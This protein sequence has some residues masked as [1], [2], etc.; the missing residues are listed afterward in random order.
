VKA[1]GTIAGT[2]R[3][4][5]SAV[6]SALL[7]VVLAGCGGGHDAAEKQ[8]EALR[9]ELVKVRTEAAILG[10]RLDALERS[11]EKVRSA[12]AAEEAPTTGADLAAAAEAD[13]PSLEVVRLAPEPQRGR[14]RG[15]ESGRERELES[16]RDATAAPLPTARL[17]EVVTTLDG[18]VDDEDEPRPVLR[19]TKGGG[20]IEAKPLRAPV[21]ARKVPARAEVR[22]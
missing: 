13:R 12:Q 22:P 17:E 21:T 20:V 19:S 11:A 2:M 5:T 7:A 18:E 6:M 1:G 10:E 14:G 3:E 9:T 16:G 4:G 8:V 15:P